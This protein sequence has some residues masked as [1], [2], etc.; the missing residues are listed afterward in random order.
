LSL[1]DGEYMPGLQCGLYKIKVSKAG[2]GGEELPA[3]YNAQTTLGRE[4]FSSGRGGGT[5][6]ELDLKK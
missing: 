4:V 5:N 2:T 1:E 6:I 3:K